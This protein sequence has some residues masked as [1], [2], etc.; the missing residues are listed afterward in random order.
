[1]QLGIHDTSVIILIYPLPL[2]VGTWDPSE[3]KPLTKPTQ[4]Y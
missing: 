2:Q 3:I 4:L 1:M